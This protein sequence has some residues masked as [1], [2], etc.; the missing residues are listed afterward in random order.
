MPSGRIRIQDTPVIKLEKKKYLA[1]LEYPF[2]DSKEQ[3]VTVL[4]TL[5]SAC[6]AAGAAQEEGSADGI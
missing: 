1:R 5:S 3:N 6:S 2:I 4:M